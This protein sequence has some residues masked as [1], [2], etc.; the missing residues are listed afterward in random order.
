MKKVLFCKFNQSR[1]PLYRTKTMIWQ[2]GEN[3]YV[4]KEPIGKAAYDHTMGIEKKYYWTTQIFQNIAFLPC[5]LKQNVVF[6]DFVDGTSLDDILHPDVKS[7]EK[8]IKKIKNILKRY[9]PVKKESVCDFQF[10]EEY[11]KIF[12]NIDCSGQKCI[13]PVNLDMAFDNICVMENGRAIAFDYEWVYDFPMPE[14]FVL[15]RMLSRF[16]DKHFTEISAQIDFEDFVAQF[17]IP[18]ELQKK[19][20]KMESAF[21]QMIYTGGE[22]VVSGTAHICERKGIY[23]IEQLGEKIE[24]KT[25]ECNKLI[26]EKNVLDKEIKEFIEKM[27]KS[28][29]EISESEKKY[30]ELECRYEDL[31]VE[32]ERTKNNLLASMEQCNQL[33]FQIRLLE[34][35]LSWRFTKP[36][37]M[38]KTLVHSIKNNGLRVTYHKVHDTIYG[39]TSPFG[40]IVPNNILR[41]Q[42]KRKFAYEPK[43]SVIT[44]LFNTPVKFLKAMI[45]SVRG[46][47]YRNWELC[48]IDFSSTDNHE[49]QEICESYAAKDRRIVFRRDPDNKGIS[50]N[51]NECLELASGEYIAML[52]HDDLLHPSAFYEVVK[53]INEEGSDFIYTDEIKF[54]DN[55]QNVFA[56]NFKP[57]FSE[58]ELRVHNYICHLNV[59]KRTLL[60]KVGEYR[61]E[62]EGSQ[63]HDMVLRL[64]E[65]AKKITHIPKILYYWR[66]HPNSVATAIEAKPYATWAGIKAVN[67]QW[68]RLGFPYKME[69]I[70]DNIPC[71]RI[72]VPDTMYE[73]IHVVIWG[74][75]QLEDIRKTLRSIRSNWKQDF[76]SSVVTRNKKTVGLIDGSIDDL[77][78]CKGIYVHDG[79][80]LDQDQINKIINNNQEEYY[81]FI[82]A[83]MELLTPNAV[84]E[85]LVFVTR[86]NIAA[87][88]TKI[89]FRNGRIFSGGVVSSQMIQ[90]HIQFRCHEQPGVDG[91]CED[92]MI[93]ARNVSAVSGIC[94]MI[95]K[96]DWLEI[97]VGHSLNC[98]P[99]ISQSIHAAE[100]G[101]Q[102]IWSA[103]VLAQG[104]LREYKAVFDQEIFDSEDTLR[105]DPYYQDNIRRYGLE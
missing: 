8:C 5:N 46:Q 44:P 73:Y 52:D 66:V 10:S 19:Y 104:D 58:E 7:V 63:D 13:K 24:E 99:F 69:S 45:E 14:S 55:L 71:Y 85:M 22:E 27:D 83:G 75:D 70:R 56:P 84:Q 68:E 54:E 90:P 11:R 94:T 39:V 64:T 92:A 105:R 30:Y 87:V 31:E 60:D 4:T 82:K 38:G 35:S 15:Y 16:Y 3:K 57:D 61:K 78:E 96:T 25:Q 28:R 50:E 21:I 53:A 103:H 37:R 77:T 12:G 80:E 18:L 1:N 47:T 86:Q 23:Q 102:L 41:M 93:H 51:T 65:V 26:E 20:Q 2:D 98:N 36:I 101:K 43:I 67:M 100:V 89:L 95:S 88:D 6:Y 40:H 9:Y 62:C 42:R 49:V 48:M 17:D 32:F 97:P 29:S 34:T 59:Y 81:L 72:Q 91:G 74:S 76:A 33:N 79:I